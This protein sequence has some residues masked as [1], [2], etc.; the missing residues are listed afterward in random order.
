MRTTKLRLRIVLAEVHEAILLVTGRNVRLSYFIV[1]NVSISPPNSKLIWIIISLR[2]T[3]FQN[4]MLNSRAIFVTKSFHAFTRYNYIKAANMVNLI[5]STI[6]ESDVIINEMDDMNLKEEL[7]S[8]Q[9]FL[10][11]SEVEG[12]RHKVLS[13]AAEKF[14]AKVVD[15]KLDHFLNNLK[16]AVKINLA[17]GFF[18]KNN[19]DGKIRYFFCTRKQ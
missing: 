7:R 4:L 14:K 19:G 12:A 10:V 8:S 18:F 3:A 5:K 1:P 6:V 2:S 15:E 17:F 11:H 16:C 9:S 13:Y